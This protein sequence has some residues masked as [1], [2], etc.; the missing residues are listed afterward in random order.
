MSGCLPMPVLLYATEC[1]ERA[2]ALAARLNFR[3]QPLATASG[4]AEDPGTCLLLDTDGLFLLRRADQVRARLEL[5]ELGR[6]LQQGRRLTLA[7][8]CGV[9]QGTTI[10]DGMAGFGLDGLTLAALGAQVTLVERDPMLYALLRD[11]V[12]RVSGD[13][14]EPPEMYCGD[15]QDYLDGDRLWDVVYLDPMFEA[16]RKQALPNKRAQLLAASGLA[17]PSDDDLLK[18][19]ALAQTHARQRVVLKRR[20]H[21]RVL[22]RPGWQITGRSVRFDVYPA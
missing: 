12:E 5:S 2:R 10:L 17:A 15:V 19:L 6:R 4:T 13:L 14:S 20:R 16:A 3:C 1:A 11:A 21:D 9:R 7:R 8:A 18:L 22:A